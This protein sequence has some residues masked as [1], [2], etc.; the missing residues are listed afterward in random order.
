[1]KKFYYI[2][3]TAFSYGTN[4]SAGACIQ[5][6]PLAWLIQTNQVM[7]GNRRYTLISWIEISEEEYHNYA[8]KL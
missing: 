6:H 8:R 5:G 4:V 7:T 3:Y 2:S 1:M